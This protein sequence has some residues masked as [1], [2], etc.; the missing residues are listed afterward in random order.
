MKE[1]VELDIDKLRFFGGSYGVRY[2]KTRHS[3]LIELKESIAQYGIRVPIIV[4]PDSLNKGK[5]EIISGETRVKA[6]KELG[7]KTV[8]AIVEVL[9]DVDAVALYGETNRYRE[10]LTKTEIAY[11]VKY[12]YENREKVKIGTAVPKTTFELKD[13]QLRDLIRVT[14][15][16]PLLQE[17]YNRNRLSIKEAAKISC[18]I[19]LNVQEEIGTVLAGT[20]K[21]LNEQIIL[22]LIA[23]QKK[24]T[25]YGE[26]C[27]ITQIEK[28]ISEGQKAKDE[29]KVKIPIRRGV[30]IKIPKE[31]NTLAKKG[32]YLEQ[33]ILEAEEDE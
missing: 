30:V 28:I 15:L 33:L 2:F 9:S 23:L 20:D 29:K 32:K 1:I 4:R 6:A 12:D 14:E 21:V 26:C 16:H 17:E 11:M 7:M 13:R 25:Q 18:N 22:R 10:D 27:D 3:K 5:Y 8:P 24:E 31:H 19:D